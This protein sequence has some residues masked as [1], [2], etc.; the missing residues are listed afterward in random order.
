MPYGA[1]SF[2][3][4]AFERGA[5]YRQVQVTVHTAELPVGLDH[6]GRAPAQRH[7]PVPP[8]LDVAGVFAANR[9]HR[10]DAIRP[11]D[12]GRKAQHRHGLV[13]GPPRRAWVRT[14]EFFRQGEQTAKSNARSHSPNRMG[15]PAGLY[16]QRRTSQRP[17]TTH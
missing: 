6:P 3:G 5:G 13:Q 2:G 15:L 14:V 12:R 8:A 16:K 11:G 9:D 4:L 1:D 10:L 17:C 7:P